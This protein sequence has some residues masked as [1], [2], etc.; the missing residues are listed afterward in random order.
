LEE[1]RRTAHALNLPE[2]PIEMSDYDA[3]PAEDRYDVIILATGFRPNLRE[4]LPDAQGVLDAHGA[5]IAT[6]RTTAEPGLYFCGQIA[7]PT[8]QL[9]EIGVEAARIAAL[10]K[11]YAAA[12]PR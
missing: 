12:N 7:S 1:G 8:G 11:R 10:A 4:L 9:R 2:R 6:G 5:P 3:S